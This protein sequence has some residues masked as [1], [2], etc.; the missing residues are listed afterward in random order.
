MSALILRLS[1]VI[2]LLIAGSLA[3]P[4]KAEVSEVRI[5]KQYGL[6]YL[7]VVIVEQQRLIE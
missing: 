5:S 2:A 7:T 1:R 3:F 6:P 4:L